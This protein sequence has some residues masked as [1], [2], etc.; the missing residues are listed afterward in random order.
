METLQ[1]LKTII[2]KINNTDPSMIN[3]DTEYRVDLGMDSVDVTE[4]LLEIEKE[5]GVL[6]EDQEVAT[7]K[8][9]GDIV[10]VIECNLEKT[11]AK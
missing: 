2:K 1:T 7:M 3:N 11:S 5:F 4:T 6:I 9:I 10:K 8:T